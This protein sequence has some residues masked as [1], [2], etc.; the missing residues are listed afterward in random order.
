LRSVTLALS[1]P[2][3]VTG[4]PMPPEEIVSLFLDGV[5]AHPCTGGASC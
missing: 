2:A 5:R 1:H 3:L 4:D